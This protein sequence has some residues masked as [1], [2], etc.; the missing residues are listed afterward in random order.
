MNA[1]LRLALVVG[2]IAVSAWSELRS[3]TLGGAELARIKAVYL[4]HFASFTEWP[5]NPESMNEIK[6]CI[7]SQGEVETQLR[8]LDGKELERGRVL[9]IAEPTQGQIAKNCNMVFLGEGSRSA[10]ERVENRLQGIPVLTISDQAGF[11]RRGGMIEMFL[12][13]DRVRMRINIGATRSSG[14]RLSS[15]LL[16]L[17]E[18]VEAP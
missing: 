13:D 5:E 1:I 16:R 7:T 14:L 8:R 2:V 15:K 12:R 17:A 9:R 3:D 18:I 6:L 11:A 10:L 4:Y